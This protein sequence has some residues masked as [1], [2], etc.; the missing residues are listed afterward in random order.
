MKR[1]H[2]NNKQG[3]EETK[4]D[5]RKETTTQPMRIR[6]GNGLEAND[7]GSLT[8]STEEETTST[9]RTRKARSRSN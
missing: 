9:T 6:G 5:K 4:K 1:K 7:R 2:I 3:K 8:D